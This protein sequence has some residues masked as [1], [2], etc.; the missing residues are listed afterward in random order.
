MSFYHQTRK[1]EQYKLFFI[2]ILSSAW[3]L[4]HGRVFPWVSS[5]FFLS[6]FIFFCV[7]LG[8]ALQILHFLSDCIIGLTCFSSAQQLLIMPWVFKPWFFRH[9]LRDCSGFRCGNMSSLQL[10]SFSCHVILLLTLFFPRVPGSQ[11]TQP[12]CSLPATPASLAEQ[13]TATV[14]TRVNP[15]LDY[16]ITILLSHTP[17]FPQAVNKTHLT[18]NSCVYVLLPGTPFLCSQTF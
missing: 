16:T 3:W 6:C 14:P 4:C 12:A 17:Q 9:S 1:G 10:S 15:D 13:T 5:V 8:V 7:S 2:R 11:L 18:L